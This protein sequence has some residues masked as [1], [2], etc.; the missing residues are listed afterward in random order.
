MP[1]RRDS[2]PGGGTS[3]HSGR[4]PP[5]ATS[6]VSGDSSSR[7]LHVSL[8]VPLPRELRI[9]T[10]TAVF[11][12]GTCFCPG[13]RIS[14]LELVVDGLPQRLSAFGMPR[15]DFFASLHPGLDPFDAT[16]LT[17]D[18]ESEDDPQLRGYAS[19]FWGLAVVRGSGQDPVT[20]ALRA[21]LAS[22]VT[23]EAPVASLTVAGAIAD[24]VPWSP[25]ARGD[26]VAICM[27]TYNP[28]PELFHRQIESIRAQ[29]HENW[30]CVVSDDCSDE[31][32]TATI[33]HEIGD[34]PRFVVSRAPRR[35]G[36]YGN[37]ER[38]LAMAPEH[39]QYLAPADQD[40]RWDADKLSVLLSRIG[41]AKLIYSDAR[42][43]SRDGTLIAD[44]YWSTR[45]NNHSDLLSL[46]V[47]N[48]VTGAAS[49]LDREVLEYALPFPPAQ[50][51]HFH[52]HWLALVARSIGEIDFVDRPLYDYVQHGAAALGHAA[53]NQMPSLRERLTARPGLHE[54][55][56]MRR[57]HYFVDVSRLL[58]VVTLLQLRCGERLGARKRRTLR[59]FARA[60]RSALYALGLGV[61][62]L[63]ELAGRPETLGAEWMLFNAFVWKRLLEATAREAPQNHLRLDAVP[64]PSLAL[65]PRAVAA[66]GVADAIAAK[67]APL[68]LAISSSSPQRVNLLIP[69][70]DLQHFFGGYIAKLNLA[71]RLA[72]CGQRVRV[73]AVDP[74]GPL[75]PNWKRQIEAYSGLDGLFDEVEVEFGRGPSPIPVSSE[76]RFIATTWWTAHVAAAACRTIGRQRFVYLIQEYE[77]FTFAMGTYAALARQSY[78]FPH[79]G[80]FSTEFL[81]DYFR[82]HQIG[83]FAAD[84][85][86]GDHMSISFQN[87]ITDVIAPT[88]SELVRRDRRKLLFY[89]RPE[90]HAARN[91]FELG[92]LALSR[93][94]ER[95]SALDGWELWGIGTVG[96]RR[97]VALG[98]GASLRLLPRSA[99]G[100]YAQLLREHDVGLALM[101]TPHPSL[102]PIEMAAGGLVTVTN[103]FENKTAQA[104][105]AISE[106]LIVVPPTIEGIV[107]GL[108]DAVAA[109]E[110]HATRI[111]A[112]DVNWSREWATS[113]SEPLLAEI[114]AALDTS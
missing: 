83:V 19:G 114:S 46:L 29:T 52:D 109:A 48:A 53:A 91:M 113:L 77:P 96:E 47:A 35:L 34:D 43:V 45:R 41:A 57:L 30:I 9:G 95:E 106:N 22:G 107:A 5:E 82:R 50:F 62:G 59:R 103:S 38:A 88:E 101:Y 26:P 23:I 69:T 8:D 33:H 17:R 97:T 42:V 16:A 28:P 74:V 56:R 87:A 92:V 76:D 70:F 15:L 54:R 90:D 1:A 80:V 89:A 3:L 108:R 12:A 85:E 14:A 31:A 25:A 21:A 65:R 60:D 86:R 102:V 55:I 10:G 27:A 58:Q 112:S 68:D 79:Y 11:V 104:M 94:L 105:A 78:D 44:T 99:Q 24:P 67:I 93:T 71:A 2:E 6:S 63:R 37:F 61:R 72:G 49:L 4:V 110:D 73:I 64:P 98:G 51:A 66:A 84:V 111:R 20:L 39:A 36:F 75:P 32:G 13:E 81:R 7:T 18:A 40:D 100:E